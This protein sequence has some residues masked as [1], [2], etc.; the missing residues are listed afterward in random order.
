VNSKRDNCVEHKQENIN[1]GVNIF[2]SI[3]NPAEAIR[4]GFFICGLFCFTINEAWW[5]RQTVRVHLPVQSDNADCRTDSPHQC[6]LAPP[7]CFLL[8]PVPWTPRHYR[9]FPM[10]S[11]RRSAGCPDQ[12]GGPDVRGTNGT[13]LSRDQGLTIPRSIRYPPELT[14]FPNGPC[15]LPGWS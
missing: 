11:C 4:A 9:F 5:N 13:A 6:G 3:K 10:S 2:L 14:G 7:G 12:T 15:F 1:Q 8:L